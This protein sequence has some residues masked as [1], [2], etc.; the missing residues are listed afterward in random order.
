MSPR[1]QLFSLLF[2]N[3]Y[4]L[5]T[6]PRTQVSL[7]HLIFIPMSPPVVPKFFAYTVFVIWRQTKGISLSPLD[8]EQPGAS[9]SRGL[10]LP[11]CIPIV[12]PTYYASSL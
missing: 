6:A 1:R 11:G 2:S 9:V 12:L 7:A 3:Q 5:K 8:V 4:V 10:V